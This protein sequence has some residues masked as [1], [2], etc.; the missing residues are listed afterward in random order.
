MLELV[1]RLG[2]ALS[3]AL[4][5]WLFFWADLTPFYSVR[6]PKP[7]ARPGESGAGS[8]LALPRRETPPVVLDVSGATAEGFMAKAVAVSRGED[9][10]PA[11]LRRVPPFE[12][13]WDR[14]REIY[15]Q[16]TEFPLAAA[17]PQGAVADRAPLVLADAAGRR[18]ELRRTRLDDASFR[19][20]SGLSAYGPPLTMVFVRRPWAGWCFGAGL[21]VYLL[22]P[23]RRWGKKWHHFARWRICLGDAGWV[24]LF[25][26]FFG[27]PLAIVG[28]SWQA[29]TVY[30]I[31]PSVLWPLAGLGLVMAWY[32]AWGAAFR[33]RLDEGGLVLGAVGRDL[34]I[35]YGDIV[36]ASPVRHR[37]PPWFL[38]LLWLAS[39]FA[40]GGAR[41]QTA[42]QAM[43]LG[44][45]DVSGLAL[46]LRNGATA[47]LWLTDAL[48]SLA[49]AGGTELVAELEKAGVSLAK[50]PRE[51]V[52]LFPPLLIEAGA[53]AGSWRVGVWGAII[54]LGP[55]L[56]VWLANLVRDLVG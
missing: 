33:V 39:L 46:E 30:G 51:L 4:G 12:R 36:N 7:A 2:L 41:F 24:L 44:A 53:R 50:K 27:L 15:F 22:L 9:V 14:P 29:L 17:V 43:L 37:Y 10:D 25:S 6:V 42:G 26:V 56:V 21:A 13:G 31:F 47:Y 23:W 1:R 20:G 32:S 55:V 18:L 3:I 38:R 52:R 5:L 40:R 35:G 54:F 11:W 45:S 16:A 28:G 34:A 19:L 8:L 48:G 49:L